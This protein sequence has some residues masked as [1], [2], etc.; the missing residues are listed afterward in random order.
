MRRWLVVGAAVLL[1]GAVA[2]ALALS[3]LNAYLIANRTSLAT[4][5]ST[6]LGRPVTFDDI[7]VSL[8]GGG[9]AR[10]TN[11][12][13]GDD[14]RFGGGD[15]LRAESAVVTVSPL[16][17]LRGLLRV[18]SVVVDAPQLTLI[19][20]AEGWNVDSLLSP[21]AGAPAAPSAPAAS[22]PATP[23]ADPPM[24]GPGIGSV[25]LRDGTL[26]VSDR[27][28]QPPTTATIDQ[29]NVR[30]SDWA[31]G[32]PL[33]LDASAALFGATAANAEIKGTVSPG[34]PT[35]ADVTATWQPIAVAAA[36]PLVPVLAQFGLQGEVGGDL[37][38]SGPLPDDGDVLASLPLSAVR[39]TLALRDVGVEHAAIPLPITGLSGS[40]SFTADA[41]ELREASLRLADAPATITCRVAPPTAPAAQCELEAAAI[42][43][44]GVG[45]GEGVVRGLKASVA[46][47]LADQTGARRA[48][49]EATG[50]QLRAASLGR[51][52]GA[53]TM[54]DDAVTLEH[55]AAEAF[56]G[57][58]QIDGAC[59]AVGGSAPDCRAHLVVRGARLSEILAGIGSDDPSRL[60]GRLDADLQVTARG[61]QPE[62][63]RRSL[64][65]GGTIGI[66]DGVVGRLN[67]AQR[68]LGA[69][70]GMSG[71]IRSG[72]RAARLLGGS[73]TRF[74][75][76]TA[77]LRIGDQRLATNDLAL[78]ASDFD[79]TASGSAGFA[80]DLTARGTFRGAAPL[81]DDL[82][83]G[84]PLLGRLAASSK[85]LIVIPFT[86][87]GTVDD[88]TVEPD[89]GAVAGGLGQDASAGFEALFGAPDPRSGKPGGVLRQGFDKLLGR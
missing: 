72:G 37:H 45:L 7:G 29:V 51:L 4:Q 60:D 2:V 69:L 35:T 12:Q 71:V 18:R 31:P 36:Q 21:A 84:V 76:L 79:V 55:A 15:F 28:R 77:T 58:L 13:V 86:V 61:R 88:P 34:N 44:H 1:A 14:P 66:T 47:P 52:S 62:A 38:F 59:T 65:G 17:A 80:G 30:I 70:P 6:A 27:A 78:T 63:L 10:I 87:G 9:S 89:F 85:G 74:S 20:D 39:G 26:Q 82:V 43:L 64:G 3:R 23:I 25:T 83:G 41:I 56:G 50:G 68:V 16:A 32:E 33:Q 40:I 54:Q 73:E 11:L 22:A 46:V 81:V 19:R 42:P 24:I 53:V 67:L 5:A 75:S 57:S 49:V 8:R 48:Q